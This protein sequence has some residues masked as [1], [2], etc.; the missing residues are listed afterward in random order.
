MRSAAGLGHQHT[1]KLQHK[2][3]QHDSHVQMQNDCIAESLH[4]IKYRGIPVSRYFLRQQAYI[5]VVHF[6]IP[7]MSK[8]NWCSC[9]KRSTYIHQWLDWDLSAPVGIQHLLSGIRHLIN[10]IAQFENRSS[11]KYF[12][13]LEAFFVAQK[14]TKIDFGYSAPLKIR[15][16]SSVASRGRE[17]LKEGSGEGNTEQN[18]GTWVGKSNGYLNKKLTL[19]SN[20]LQM[21]FDVVDDDI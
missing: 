14:D 17:E 10:E 4:E 2:C 1:L 19:A 11:S 12:L 8:G 21:S 6:L 7:R 18:R 9:D 5:I 15:R 20:N 16:F 13:S 3:K